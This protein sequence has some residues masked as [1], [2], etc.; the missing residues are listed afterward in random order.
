M[1]GDGDQIG[2]EARLLDGGCLILVRL[3]YLE[4]LFC[5]KVCIEGQQ[6]GESKGAVW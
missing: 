5:M 3:H 1:A 4:V 6:G 2:H